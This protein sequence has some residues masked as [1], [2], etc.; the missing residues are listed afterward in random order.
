MLSKFVNP[1]FKLLV[2]NNEIACQKKSEKNAMVIQLYPSL[3]LNDLILSL[4]TIFLIIQKSASAIMPRFDI[5]KDKGT[6]EI[7]KI[8]EK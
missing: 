3:V 8:N 4:A 2:Y 5:L 6:V 1:T 7:I